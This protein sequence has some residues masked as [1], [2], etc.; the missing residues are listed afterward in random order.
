MYGFTKVDFD[1][2]DPI[3]AMIF[4]SGNIAVTD[5]TQ[6]S[7]ND[8][9]L[10]GVAFSDAPTGTE[11]SEEILEELQGEPVASLDPKF[12]MLFDNP[13]SID[14]VIRKLQAAKELMTTCAA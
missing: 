1:G 4:G 6:L 2:G 12:V 5:I 11:V 9:L 3:H 13:N 14:V 7:I 8:T 10:H